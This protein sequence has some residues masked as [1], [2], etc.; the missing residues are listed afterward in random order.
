MSSGSW[1]RNP[2][3]LLIA[4]MIS[5]AEQ[6]FW[7]WSEKHSEIDIPPGLRVVRQK[8]PEPCIDI[9]RDKAVQ[10][11]IQNGARW[12][13]FW[14]TDVILPRDG[15]AKLL[16]A[17]KPIIA[18]HYVRRHNPPFNEGLRFRPDGIAG[19]VP[20]RDGDYTP[21]QIVDVDCVA[22]GC[23]LVKTE[24]FE[25][26]KPFEITIDGRPARQAYFLWTEWRL[27]GGMSEDFSFA[28]RAKMQGIPVYWHT[29]VQCQHMGPVK[30]CPSGNN[31]INIKFPGEF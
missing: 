21:G 4:H 29:G 11:A 23:L 7:D 5:G 3:D 14:D 10:L 13:F 26:M 22:T 19:V 30:F 1:E 9:S 12:I 25:K 18:G 15:L 24:V 8:F 2:C 31:T 20:M 16:A 17:D 6:V 28:T 27:P